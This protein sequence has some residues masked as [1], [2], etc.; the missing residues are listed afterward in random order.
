MLFYNKI[1]EYPYIKCRF[2]L[3]L[4]DRYTLYISIN[5][6]NKNVQHGDVYVRRELQTFIKLNNILFS[7][8]IFIEPMESLPNCHLLELRVAILNLDFNILI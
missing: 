4:T 5:S 8:C 3:F 6:V 1:K 2:N 7:V